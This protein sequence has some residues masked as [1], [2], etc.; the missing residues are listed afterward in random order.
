MSFQ[1]ESAFTPAPRARVVLCA[2]RSSAPKAR[3][4]RV[5]P[6][7]A[8]MT[9]VVLKSWQRAP[10]AP[11]PPARALTPRWHSAQSRSSLE[12]AQFRT[13]LLVKCESAESTNAGALTLALAFAGGS[14]P[15]SVALAR[16]RARAPSSPCSSSAPSS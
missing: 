12:N 16:A 10:C 15:P 7:R 5:T 8:S 2:R 1:Y 13:R 6:G 11:Q 14:G 3:V 4:T 9:D